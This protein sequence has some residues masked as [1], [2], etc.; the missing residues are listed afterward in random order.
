MANFTVYPWLANPLFWLSVSLGFCALLLLVAAVLNNTSSRRTTADKDKQRLRVATI[1]RIGKRATQEDAYAASKLQRGVPVS[2]CGLLAV[3]AD[4]MGGLSHGDVLSRLAVKSFM[5][6]FSAEQSCANPSHL[7]MEYLY[8]ANQNINNHLEKERIAR[9][10]TT[11]VAA[12]IEGGELHYLS[13]GDS[14]IYLYRGGGLIQLNREHTYGNRLDR[15]ALQNPGQFGKA[16]SSLHR[17]AITDYLG[18]GALRQADLPVRPVRLKPKDKVLLASDGIFSA[19][20][21]DDVALLMRFSA[22]KAATVL[23]QQI[24]KKK[25]PDQDNYTA[26]IIGVE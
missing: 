17:D 1:H 16:R 14:R 7:L 4:G 20:D 3:V 21:E 6:S 12:I 2:P 25:N 24:E 9:A 8:T 18:M 13:V 10:G 11:L 19:L 15:L 5:A 23:E 22:D 26:V